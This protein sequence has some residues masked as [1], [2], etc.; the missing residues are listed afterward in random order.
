MTF[1][2]AIFLFLI[3]FFQTDAA[4]SHAEP[5]TLDF[6]NINVTDVLQVIAKFSG[7]NFVI[8]PNVNG[9]VSLH[10][11][12]ASVDQTL[13]LLL[14]SQGL[15]KRVMG[16]VWYIAP[17][18]ELH[19]RK[20]EELQFQAVLD[21]A[22]SLSTR[23]WQVRYAKAQDIGRLIQD[24]NLSLLSKRGH[25]QVDTRTNTVSIED[26]PVNLN[27]VIALIKKLDVPVKQVLI[28]ARLASVDSDYERELGISY[29]VHDASE[30]PNVSTSIVHGPQF[31]L[32][33]A[34]L[35]N[36]NVLDVALSALE[37]EGHG[38]LISSPSLFTSNQQPALIESGEE[39]PYQ[40]STSSGATSV[41]FKK[42][43][44]SLQVT[45]QIM[46]GNKVLLQLKVNQDKPSNRIVQ[47]VP[48][49]T[50]RQI[51]TSLLI[52]NAQTIVLGGI[53][54]LDNEHD[55]RRIPFLGDIPL[56]G[57]LFTQQNIKANKRE[58]LIFVTPKIIS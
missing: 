16:G 52:N 38:K 30:H 22:A 42:A 34:T 7:R 44:L 18:E 3:L 58:L 10:L 26:L 14:A 20:I 47:G 39:I 50:T 45:P 49:I 40:E 24:A 25:V 29:L 51:A 12:N 15:S 21:E 55:E 13:N 35:A 48:A 43:V 5:I 23:V 8:S 27:H 33:V 36:S 28:E 2:K 9:L 6:K 19:K 46:P 56:V 54:E 41:V 57:A 31:S 32:A 17:I 53:Y 4:C 37:N 1:L 11:V